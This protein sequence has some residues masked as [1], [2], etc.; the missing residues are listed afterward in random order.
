LLGIF[1]LGK[2]YSDHRLDAACARA[3]SIGSTSYSSIES[4]LKSG[5][6]GKPVADHAGQTEPVQHENIRGADYYHTTLQ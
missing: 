5:L 6:D 2:S 3:L 1:R 4:I